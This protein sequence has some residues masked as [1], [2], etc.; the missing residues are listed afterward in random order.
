MLCSRTDKVP[1]S[2]QTFFKRL[3]NDACVVLGIFPCD[4]LAIAWVIS[5]TI[6]PAKCPLKSSLK[7]YLRTHAT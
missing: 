2:F 3:P 6:D 4:M 7:H 1:D 5:E